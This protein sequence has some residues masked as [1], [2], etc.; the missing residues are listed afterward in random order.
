MKTTNQYKKN[1]SQEKVNQKGERI[2][3]HVLSRSMKKNEK[4]K[5]SRL[6]YPHN[7]AFQPSLT[8]IF[9]KPAKKTSNGVS[10]LPQNKK[11]KNAG[12]CGAE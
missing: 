8:N 9:F 1:N 3:V 2:Q 4:K 5:G 12:H 6:S 11:K 7:R 10:L